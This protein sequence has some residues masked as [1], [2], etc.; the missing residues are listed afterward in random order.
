MA[1]FENVLFLGLC[2][3]GLIVTHRIVRG[4]PFWR[5]REHRPQLDER[6]IMLDRQFVPHSQRRERFPITKQHSTPD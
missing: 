4:R 2:L 6:W 3:C 5:R 1:P